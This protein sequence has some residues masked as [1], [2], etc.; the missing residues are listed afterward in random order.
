MTNHENAS[1]NGG[2]VALKDCSMVSITAGTTGE[3]GSSPP[4]HFDAGIQQAQEEDKVK[5]EEVH[6]LSSSP[7]SSLQPQASTTAREDGPLFLQMKTT[8]TTGTTVLVGMSSIGVDELPNIMVEK[9]Q[10]LIKPVVVSNDKN[11]PLSNLPPP[12]QQQQ[13]N[14]VIKTSAS[15]S[16][17]TTSTNGDSAADQHWYAAWKKNLQECIHQRPAEEAVLE[18]LYEENLLQMNT[19]HPKSSGSSSSAGNS[20]GCIVSSSLTGNNNNNSKSTNKHFTLIRGPRGSGKTRLARSVLQKK[21]SKA[22]TSDASSSTN[23]AGAQAGILVTGKFDASNQLL[24]PYQ[25][26]ISAISDYCNFVWQRGCPA[27]VAVA[28]HQTLGNEVSVLTNMIPALSRIL[29]HAA[30]STTTNKAT[31]QQKLQK[32]PGSCTTSSNSV[33]MKRFLCAFQVLLGV[34][35]RLQPLVLLLDGLQYA[36]ECSLDLLV[37]IVTNA[38]CENSGLLVIA[39]IDDDDADD[40]YGVAGANDENVLSSS[41]S[42]M[43]SSYL[44]AKLAEI[45]DG[46]NVTIVNIG[47]KKLENERVQQLLSETLEWDDNETVCNGLTST[48]Y[49]QTRGNPFFT[50]AFICRL[51][52]QGLLVRNQVTGC[53]TL[54][55]EEHSSL[56]SLSAMRNTSSSS[57]AA[58]AAYNIQVFLG[59]QLRK[60]PIE[61]LDVLKVASCFGSRIQEQLVSFVL[62]YPVDKHLIQA[63]KHGIIFYEKECDGYFFVHDIVQDAV[64]ELTPEQ[65][66]ELFHLEVGRRLWRKLDSGSLDRNIYVVLSQM[67][68]G[69]RLISREKELVAIAT[70][71]LHAG[72][73]AAESSS[74][75]IA[76]VY[77]TFGIDL[78]TGV[79]WRDQYDLLLALHNTSAEMLMYSGKF[80]QMDEVVDAV[81]RH[82]RVYEDKI[83]VYSTRIW[84]L[85]VTDR[86]Q[87]CA[88]LGVEVLKRLGVRIPRCHCL[89]YVEWKRVRKLLHGKSDEQL[90]RLPPLQD[91][92]I[93]QILRILQF[94]QLHV[95]VARPK[96]APFVL[97]ESIKLTLQHGI[98]ALAP[99]AFCS[100]SVLCIQFNQADDSLR[101]SELALLML[102][103][104]DVVEYLVSVAIPLLETFPSSM[105]FNDTSFDAHHHVSFSFVF[106]SH[107]CT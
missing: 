49:D 32:A 100:Y 70:L 16:A 9:Q 23:N 101:Y 74:F 2:E 104:M 54:N 44:S 95:L 28:I 94:I 21:M 59:E 53:W 96:F 82:A 98:S 63:E 14:R 12:Q 34:L 13:P 89:P 55:G 25:A 24:A 72:N 7:A 40:D 51:V 31:C 85:G 71:C 35:A 29:D 33:A 58:A 20:N 62:G 39:T 107:A 6:R 86:Q 76:C 81:I 46:G 37:M 79:S 43:C 30:T 27:A 60:Y 73:K 41:S 5:D 67:R 84:A 48:V 19:N 15:S 47:L 45:K 17:A 106:N 61:L 65:D 75:R 52:E 26:Y 88:D 22:T 18:K 50:Y 78:L 99:L 83:E 42:P 64:D 87:E 1:T 90:L 10:P 93:A 56:T 36:D 92:R 105:T 11:V 8:T 3:K 103:R 102:K 66:R 57:A 4:Q 77:L 80:S 97:L 69:R 38:R 91:K 68:L